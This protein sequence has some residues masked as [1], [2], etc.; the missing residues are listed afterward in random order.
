MRAP[1]EE[2]DAAD[3]EGQSGGVDPAALAETAV[4]KAEQDGV[5]CTVLRRGIQGKCI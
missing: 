4:V 2:V 1:P 3:G 5:G